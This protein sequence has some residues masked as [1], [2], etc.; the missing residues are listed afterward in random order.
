MEFIKPIFKNLFEDTAIITNFLK[1][2][3]CNTSCFEINAWF[4]ISNN[5][6]LR[7]LIVRSAHSILKGMES[8]FRYK[9]G[10]DK[11]RARCRS[12]APRH[13]KPLRRTRFFGR[14]H[15]AL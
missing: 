14:S 5:R 10:L 6:E 11:L 3:I 13:A 8:R 2:L 9:S 12:D 7:N 4:A 15:F 1:S